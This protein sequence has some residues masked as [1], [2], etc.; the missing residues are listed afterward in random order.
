MN[1]K[2]KQVT[3][4]GKGGSEEKTQRLEKFAT[5]IEPS[6][7]H[8]TRLHDL[9]MLILQEEPPAHIRLYCCPHPQRAE[10]KRIIQETQETQII[11]P[12][13]SLSMTLYLQKFCLFVC[14]NK[15]F[16][17]CHIQLNQLWL[18]MQHSQISGYFHYL[19]QERTMLFEVFP[20]DDRKKIRSLQ[21]QYQHGIYDWMKIKILKEQEEGI[22]TPTIYEAST[23]TMPSMSVLALPYR[24]EVFEIGADKT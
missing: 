2:A 21:Q 11:R 10:A 12:R 9:R 13:P 19:S 15:L 20:I 14:R 3:L 22:H 18:L 4:H 24:N 6:R 7:F 5:S 8:P 1:G 23:A 16:L 17:K